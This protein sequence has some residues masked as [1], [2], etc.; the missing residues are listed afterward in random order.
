MNVK[1]VG[2]TSEIALRSPRK[3]VSLPLPYPTAKLSMVLYIK[4]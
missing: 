1:E 3:H 4:E 2:T